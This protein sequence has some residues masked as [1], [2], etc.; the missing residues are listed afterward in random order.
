MNKRI[1]ATKV[2]IFIETSKKRKKKLIA[3]EDS[4]LKPVKFLVFLIFLDG[5]LVPLTNFLRQPFGLD[6]FQPSTS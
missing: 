1:I 2:V 6:N 4:F 5:I 3:H